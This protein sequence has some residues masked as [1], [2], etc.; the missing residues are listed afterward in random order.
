MK[1][2]AL[3]ASRFI[4]WGKSLKQHESIEYIRPDLGTD[5]LRQRCVESMNDVFR[6]DKAG[7]SM[8]ATLGDSTRNQLLIVGK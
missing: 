8:Y 7:G 6:W 5:E 4:A 3:L 1:L 2:G